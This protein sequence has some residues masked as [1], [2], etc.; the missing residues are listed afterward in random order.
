MS[1][2]PDD[3]HW[4]DEKWVAG[5]WDTWAERFTTHY[6]LDE[7]QQAQLQDLLEGPK[8][9]RAALT[10]RAHQTLHRQGLP[11]R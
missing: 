7:R 5:S 4:L 10:G 8:D 11:P 2:D 3:L 1:G 9:F 6:R